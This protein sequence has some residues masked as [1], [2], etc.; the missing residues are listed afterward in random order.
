[1]NQENHEPLSE[2]RR[3]Y[4]VKEFTF[5]CYPD[6]PTNSCDA[7]AQSEF[8]CHSSR[9]L[10]AVWASRTVCLC[11][12]KVLIELK[13]CRS[14]FWSLQKL[15]VYQNVCSSR[16]KLISENRNVSERNPWKSEVEPTF[17]GILA[18]PWRFNAHKR[19][20]SILPYN[21]IKFV[22]THCLF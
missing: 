19:S 3:G 22:S 12:L 20:T 16:I 15:H 8:A 1:M 2:I 9:G 4:L 18:V 10:R 14:N 11:Y 13:N 21:L 7:G 5:T 6:R 17:S